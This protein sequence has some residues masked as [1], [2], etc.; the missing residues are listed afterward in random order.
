M[1]NLKKK[2]IS[3]RKSIRKVSAGASLSV[4]MA[5]WNA[6]WK[7]KTWQLKEKR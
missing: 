1:K 5:K 3:K 6:G 7:K 2:K 4:A